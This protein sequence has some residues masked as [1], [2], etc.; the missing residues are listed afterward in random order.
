M[1]KNFENKEYLEL[2]C[3][4]KE[5]K[6]GYLNN[7]NSKSCLNFYNVNKVPTLKYIK[8]KLIKLDQGRV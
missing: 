2:E 6:R 8:Y 5:M 7:K 3:M 1:N 4:E